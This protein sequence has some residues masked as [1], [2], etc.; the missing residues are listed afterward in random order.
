L[1][2]NHGLVRERVDAETRSRG[3]NADEEKRERE[4]TVTTAFRE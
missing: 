1:G 4:E 3:G 2:N